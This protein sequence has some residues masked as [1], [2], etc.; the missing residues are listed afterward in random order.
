MRDKP[1]IHF[2]IPLPWSKRPAKVCAHGP[3]AVVVASVTVL[4]VIIIIA[5]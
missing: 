1:F 3:M 2:E 5:A 4:L